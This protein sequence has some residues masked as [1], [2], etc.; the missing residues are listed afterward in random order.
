MNE[1]K[2]LHNLAF[3]APYFVGVALTKLT[4]LLFVAFKIL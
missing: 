4:E 3:A 2:K 1:G